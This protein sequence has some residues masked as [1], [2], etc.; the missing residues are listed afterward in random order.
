LHAAIHSQTT[1]YTTGKGWNMTRRR[2]F[3][4][5]AAAMVA[6]CLLALPGA[7]WAQGNRDSAFERVLEVQQRH[8]DQMMAVQGVVGTAVGLDEDNPALLVLLE[9]EGVTG[10][11]AQVDGVKVKKLVTGRIYALADKTRYDRPV[12]IGVSTGNAGECSAGTIACRVTDGSNVYALSNNHVYAL[13]NDAASGSNV[14]QPGLYDT[15]CILNSN[16]AIGT[17]YDFK[18]IDF[19]GDNT[20]D[21]AIALTTTDQ[22]GTATPPDGYGTPRSTPVAAAFQMSV[23][24]RGRTTGLTTGTITGLDATVD[25]SYGSGVAR[26][27]GQIVISGRRFSAAG[28]SGSLI[29]T[30][31]DNSPVGLLFAG[32]STVTIANPIAEVLDYFGV[33]IDDGSGAPPEN[34]APIADFSWAT[35]GLAVT[36]TD[37]SYDPDGD[38]LTYLWEFGDNT[39][40]TD[41]NPTMHTYAGSGTYTVTLTVTDDAGAWDSVSAPVSVSDGQ[42]GGVMSVPGVSYATSGGKNG[43][44]HLLVSLSVVDDYSE[45]VPGASVSI[46][47]YRGGSAYKTA[48]GTTGSDGGVTFS[49]NN[50]P[51]GTYTTTVT[52]VVADGLTWDG[53]QPADPGFNK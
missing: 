2:F 24:K 45:P 36:F 23:Q 48:S 47:L 44:R 28:D 37:E 3:Q 26:F 10:I 35:D 14:V 32:N 42:P 11:P 33:H 18:P 50:A 49:F 34:Q 29:V 21:A 4:A 39:T 6:V 1:I 17:L 27:V 43:D 12:P 13:E 30:Q 19:S 20:I 51:S 9:H 31:A 15:R 22:V 5:F 7:L 52:D 46:Q 8:T 41:Q 38:P 25:V 40:S 53:I 16:N